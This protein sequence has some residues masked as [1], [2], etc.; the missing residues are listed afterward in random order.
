MAGT[1]YHPEG[2]RLR[3]LLDSFFACPNPDCAHMICVNCAEVC[4]QPGSE[5]TDDC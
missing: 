1:G 2:H 5:C 4:P 3:P